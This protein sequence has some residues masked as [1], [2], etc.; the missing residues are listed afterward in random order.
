MLD[1]NDSLL[2]CDFC[3]TFDAPRPENCLSYQC[4]CIKWRSRFVRYLKCVPFLENILILRG[5]PILLYIYIHCNHSQ[6]LVMPCCLSFVLVWLYFSLAMHTSFM[7]PPD[8]AGLLTRKYDML[9][10]HGDFKPYLSYLLHYNRDHSTTLIW[11][12]LFSLSMSQ[13][14]ADSRARQTGKVNSIHHRPKFSSTNIYC[15]EY[16]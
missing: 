3:A 14:R 1:A 5:L 9:N 6:I 2:K 8:L 12:Q 15:Q 4:K 13:S 16:R 7:A 10:F 11:I